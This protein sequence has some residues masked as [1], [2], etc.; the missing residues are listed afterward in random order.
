MASRKLT[1]S[2]PEDLASQFVRTVPSAKRSQYVA[3]AI[4]RGLREREEML[5]EA[6]EAANNDP[7]T[8]EIEREMNALPD[9]MTEAWN[10]SF[11]KAG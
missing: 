2:L 9:T 1:F 3:D 6:C 11:S 8:Q 4:M 10:A 5:I 7:E